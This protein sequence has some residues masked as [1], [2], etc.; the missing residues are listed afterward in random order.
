[1]APRHA[2]RWPVGVSPCRLCGLIRRCG[3]AQCA[4]YCCLSSY[5]TL[6]TCSCSM[7]CSLVV[8][9]SG[10]LCWVLSGKCFRCRDSAPSGCNRRPCY[11]TTTTTC[12]RDWISEQDSLNPLEW[13]DL[14]IYLGMARMDRKSFL[15]PTYMLSYE[16]CTSRV[17]SSPLV[18]SFSS[19]KQ[20]SELQSAVPLSAR[21]YCTAIGRGV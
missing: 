15:A 2:I 6:H 19:C 14:Y 13:K 1:M 12:R 20:T 18:F 21:G 11:P 3:A 7:I 9:F 4:R 16:T 5:C 8:C 17:E 10:I